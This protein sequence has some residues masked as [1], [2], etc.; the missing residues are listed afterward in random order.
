FQQRLQVFFEAPD[1]D[2]DEGEP[3][4][5]DG[6]GQWH[7]RAELIEA[8]R[9]SSDPADAGHAIQGCLDRMRRRGALVAGG[10]GEAAARALYDSVREAVDPYRNACEAWPLATDAPLRMESAVP[11]TGLVFEDTLAGWRGD[12]RG[13]WGR[14]VLLA[15]HLVRDRHYRIAPMMP[16][17]LDHLAAHAHGRSLT[18]VIVSP[19]GCVR[20]GPLEPDHAAR[21][22]QVLWAA[23]REGMR[24]APPVEIDTAGAWLRAGADPDPEGKA[25]RT[26]EDMYRKRV[27][28]DLY[29][30]RCYPDFHSLCADDG[31][32]HWA[33]TL[34]GAASRAILPYPVA[35][36]GEA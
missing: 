5:R 8:L 14:I 23:W 25:W 33:E 15:S 4:V 32:F 9:R 19:Q 7:L 18:T 30:R 28:D 26:A 1:P 24:A 22:W 11:D 16:A 34:Y 3:Y 36:E 2:L 10:L 13:G 21:Q 27:D 12:G 35:D 31:F 6:L 17:W 29:L 20:F